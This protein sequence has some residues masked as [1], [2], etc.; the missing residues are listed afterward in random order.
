MR[1]PDELLTQIAAGEIPCPVAD[2][3]HTTY[4]QYVTCLGTYVVKFCTA[5][6]EQKRSG[7]V[8]RLERACEYVLANRT[9][10]TDQKASAKIRNMVK[11]LRFDLCTILRD[12]VNPRV[13]Q[14][15]DEI[16]KLTL[17]D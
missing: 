10:D 12:E 5:L 13:D 9:M 7:D 14:Y 16:L 2:C 1:T 17:A 4:D 3:F 15:L 11:R 6:M 8:E